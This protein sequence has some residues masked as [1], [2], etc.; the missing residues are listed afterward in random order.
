V[1]S[2]NTQSESARILYFF[3]PGFC[4]WLL[5]QLQS[6]SARAPVIAEVNLPETVNVLRALGGPSVYGI[7]SKPVVDNLMVLC[8]LSPAVGLLLSDLVSFHGTSNLQILQQPQVAYFDKH[9]AS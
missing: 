3:V 7:N 8:A 5:H 2:P 1:R 6:I 4:V 9:S